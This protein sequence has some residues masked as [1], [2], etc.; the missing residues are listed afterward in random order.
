M[1]IPAAQGD[2]RRY[3]WDNEYGSHVSDVPSFK[4]GCMLV[5]NA[6]Y[7]E[8][9][10][11]GG[12]QND[13]YWNEEGL[14]WRNFAQATAPTF[15]IQRDG[16]WFLRLMCEEIPMPWDWPVDVN[17][18]EAEA[19]CRWKAI[20]TGLPFRLPT[21]DEWVRLYDI[22]GITPDTPAQW[23][24]SGSR[25]AVPINTFVHGDFY[26][27]VGNAWQWT[28][29]PIYPFAGFEA[30]PLYDDFSIPT[31]D[32]R[33]NLM[34]GGAGSLVVTRPCVPHAMRSDAISFSMP[35]SD[36]SLVV[37][38]L[39]RRCRAMK[40]MHFWHSMPS[41]ISGPPTSMCRTSLLRWQQSR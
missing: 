1:R 23:R 38:R 28:C 35:G 20:D 21:E 37:R 25:S 2:A 11:A 6:E 27:V 30:H 4:A 41:S 39:C 40:M 7:L 10:E 8:F 34:K 31:F 18:L 24:L 15:W 32:E 14:G 12:Y 29:T 9:V 19:F 36:M 5:S 3:G 33:H 17:C 16:G 13:A 26:D 22:A